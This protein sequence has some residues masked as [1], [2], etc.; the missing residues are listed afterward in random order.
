MSTVP[1][2]VLS[3]SSTKED[4]VR[5]LNMSNE[6]YAL[7]AK[8]ADIIYKRLILDKRHLKN[9]CKRRPPYDWS[10][11]VEK[12]KDDAMRLIAAGGTPHTSYYWNLAAETDD[13]PNWI[14]RWF[15]YHKFRYR[16]GRNRNQVRGN[17]GRH[18]HHKN[19]RQ[20]HHANNGGRQEYSDYYAASYYSGS[21]TY[22]STTTT[23]SYASYDSMRIVDDG[24]DQE[25]SGSGNLP[26]D[27][28]RDTH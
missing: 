15:L 25:G 8:E 14:A 10:D 9:N 13:C 23:D 2:T 17:D 16:D 4:L 11:I 20:D 1:V 19:S 24:A 22:A 26:Y 12:S 21:T 7:M 28:V 18:S 6:S 3:M 5:N 27:P